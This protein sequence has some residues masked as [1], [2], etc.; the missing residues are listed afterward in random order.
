MLFE[1]EKYYLLNYFDLE[2]GLERCYL[3]NSSSM[4]SMI[5]GPGSGGLQCGI[6]KIESSLQ[7]EGAPAGTRIGSRE[8]TICTIVQIMIEHTN[9]CSKVDSCKPVLK[10]ENVVRRQECQEEI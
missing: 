9:R 8:P 3:Q 4:G 1:I 6:M 10:I 7:H 5:N 2:D